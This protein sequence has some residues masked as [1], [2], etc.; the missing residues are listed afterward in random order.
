MRFRFSIFLKQL[1]VITPLVCIPAALVAYFSIQASVE[2][3]NRLV[4]QEQMVQ[5]EAAAAKI[6]HA[7]VTCG[8]DLDTISGLPVLEDFYLSRAFNL[9]AEEEFN[10]ETLLRLF[11]EFIER[12]PHYYQI[13]FLD[14]HGKEVAKAGRDGGPAT[15]ENAGQ[16][17]YFLNA[18]RL[19]PDQRFISRLYASKG[20]GGYLMHWARPVYTGWRQ[21]A[22]VAVIDMDFE[23][24]IR[25][26]RSV[27]VGNRGHSFLMDSKGQVIFHPMFPPY[28][29]SFMKPYT[30]SLA[31]MIKSMVSGET[32][33]GDYVFQ[34]E[35]KAAAY[36]P[37][38]AMQWSLAVTIPLEE[39]QR[40]SQELKTRLFQVMVIALLF[41]LA[42]ALILSYN[43]VRPVRRLV[44]A[45]KRIAGGDL[46]HEIPVA[47][48]DELGDLTRSFNQMVKNL[49]R[50]QQEL[51]RSE[52]LISLGRLSAGV[53][54]E[55][56]NP[57]NAM[58]GAVVHMARRRKS[59]P[60]VA[61]YTAL[62]SEEIDRLNRFVGEF[63][64]FAKQSPPRPEPVELESLCEAVETLFA[65][66]AASRGI[67]FANSWD[68]SIPAMELD[69]YQI[70]QV[71]INLVI[72]SMDAMPNG[73]V[74]T[75]TTKMINLNGRPGA[76]IT[77]SDQGMGVAP[78]HKGNLFDPF[79]TTKE[80]GT[81]LGLPLSLG[82]VEGH[83]GSIS[84][85]DAP[86]GGTRAIVDLPLRMQSSGD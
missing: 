60:L 11:R 52:K 22:G 71:L 37:I 80:S 1:L 77:V 2:R 30:K 86:G 34:E 82:I 28:M 43:L 9:K 50:T 45:T 57:L 67:S 33:W 8:I 72:N 46:S 20:R 58:K 73:G 15:L 53:A 59:D 36:A 25:L 75:M 18:M 84:L 76:R 55:I 6:N 13:R 79:F 41:A 27:R 81:G 83:G 64:Y 16:Q 32:G 62:V 54:H 7:L 4:R 70:E 29:Y 47:S 85:E 21:L 38:P 39:Y 63:L 78:E 48:Q 49:S 35:R 17:P 10:R 65:E 26:L 14:T 74:I 5:A 51:V 42:A 24:I 12:N 19:A 61:E 44:A 23:P 40:E 31:S 56:R 66:Q 68:P 69:P 3:V